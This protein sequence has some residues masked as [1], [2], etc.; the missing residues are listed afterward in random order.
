LG[1]TFSVVALYANGKYTVIDNR[2]GNSITPSVVYYDEECVARET[3]E[4]AVQM[5]S[6]YASRTFRHVKRMIGVR[7]KD[8][9]DNDD[10][11]GYEVVDNK[12]YAAFRINN[13][14]VIPPAFISA[15]VLKELTLSAREFIARENPLANLSLPFKAAVTV[16][17]YFNNPKRKATKDAALHAGIDVINLYSEPVAASMYMQ[18]DDDEEAKTFVVCDMGGG[19][20]DVTVNTVNGGLYTVESTNGD[21]HLGGMDIDKLVMEQLRKQC[22]MQKKVPEEGDLDD[23]AFMMDQ[24]EKVKIAFG[25]E[26]NH[27]ESICGMVSRTS[28]EKLL[29]GPGAKII[30]ITDDAI[31]KA[32]L[33]IDKI[34]KVLFVGGSARIKYFQR[35]LRTHYQGKDI[36]ISENPDH[37]IALGAA[38]L[39]A[40][41]C[42]HGPM[43]K[44][45][46]ATLAQG[47]GI[48]SV[49]G[50]QEV[51]TFLITEN[52]NVPTHTCKTFST[53]ADNQQAVTVQV[54]QGF[55]K[56]PKENEHIGTVQYDGLPRAPAGG[57]SVEICFK[58]NE[59]QIMTVSV[60]GTY[61]GAEEKVT[62]LS[63]DDNIPEEQILERKKQAEKNSELFNYIIKVE[64]K[65]SDARYTIT[66]E[67]TKNS[68]EESHMK[69][70]T[71]FL[72]QWDKAKASGVDA[73]KLK[74]EWDPKLKEAEPILEKIA[75]AK[76]DALKKHNESKN[77]EGSTAKPDPTTQQQQQD[78]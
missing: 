49:Q 59:E 10:F 37:A 66:S 61:D 71:D 11:K 60:K 18:G 21:N 12:G 35:L 41:S 43:E 8:L 17:A 57:A 3:G 15:E 70:I 52:T 30:K 68:I 42:N 56:N 62:T 16:P 65:L 6:E 76:A 40:Q 28:F 54:L 47:Y 2:V 50:N 13:K 24:A 29:I 74:A 72:A 64:E 5:A 1:T 36:I 25:G 20:F 34:D 78:L 9:P 58:V 55:S 23:N 7:Y 31:S 73:D 38:Q 44:V 46:I 26:G 67:L 63:L 14:C 19:T 51:T 4:P 27:V 33:T 69:F 45:L 53:A 77:A 75:I 22:K 39:A 48:V 32:G